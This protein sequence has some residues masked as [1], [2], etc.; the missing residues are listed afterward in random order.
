M[1][2]FHRVAIRPHEALSSNTSNLSNA[3]RTNR[4]ASC[5]PHLPNEIALIKRL[6][7]YVIN[8]M[9]YR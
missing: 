1:K 5:R 4:P 6:I 7:M 8:L 2:L 3:S 9:V